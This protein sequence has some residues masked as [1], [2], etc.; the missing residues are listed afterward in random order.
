MKTICQEW[1]FWR[2]LNFRTKLKIFHF[3][4]SMCSD[5]WRNF[6][7]K[8]KGC[9][10]NI[11]SLASSFWNLKQKNK[12]IKHQKQQISAFILPSLQKINAMFKKIKTCFYFFCYRFCFRFSFF[13]FFYEFFFFGFI[14]FNLNYF[15]V[16]TLWD[17][18]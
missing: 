14:F 9:N 16:K 5:L 11:D 4:K 1:S 17:E 12:K 13:F 7:Q 8:I 3:S 6:W 10:K 18:W 15:Y 2:F